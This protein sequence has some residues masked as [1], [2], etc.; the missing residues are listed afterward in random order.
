MATDGAIES[1]KRNDLIEYRKTVDEVWG[2]K[3]ST[4]DD[5]DPLA[6]R[7]QVLDK[8]LRD[9]MDTL[10]VVGTKHWHATRDEIRILRGELGNVGCQGLGAGVVARCR[11]KTDAPV[12]P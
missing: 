7:Y 1:C 10:A 3:G 12:Q 6:V 8:K 9:D 2:K 5:D 4:P 11:L